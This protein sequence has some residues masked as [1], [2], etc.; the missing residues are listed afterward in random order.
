VKSKKKNNKARKKKR[1]KS[2]MKRT[3]KNMK[4]QFVIVG[5]LTLLVSVVLS[6]CNSTE[7]IPDVT[8]DEL[9]IGQWYNDTYNIVLNYTFYENHSSCLTLGIKSFWM[10]YEITEDNIIMKNLSD[11]SSTFYEYFFTNNNQK[12]SITSSEGEVIVLTRR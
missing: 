3:K 9:I 8:P 7:Q 1:T 2:R 4:K 12:L 10:G 6:G 5:I 11:G